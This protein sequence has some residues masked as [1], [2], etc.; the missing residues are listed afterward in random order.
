VAPAVGHGLVH[1]ARASLDS[2]SVIEPEALLAAVGPFRDPKVGA[3][4][5][6]VL[7]F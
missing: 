4:A 2:D 6:R 1:G 5:G 3:V 7:V